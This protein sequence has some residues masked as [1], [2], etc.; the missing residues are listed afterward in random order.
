MQ[1]QEIIDIAR[2]CA[3]LLEEKKSENILILDLKEI[4]SYLDYFILS[5][6]N[7]L[8]HCR[9]LGTELR[10]YFKSIGFKERTH[11]KLDSG[12]IVLDFNEIIIHIFTKD[13]REYYQLE[14]L[15]ADALLINF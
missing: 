7:S 11:S 15:W 3:R 14:N 10:R 13:M 6:G 4:N 1:E 5:T 8:L 9:S 12:W 2:N